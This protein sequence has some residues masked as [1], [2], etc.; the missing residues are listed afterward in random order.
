MTRARG[1]L[2]AAGASLAMMPSHLLFTSVLLSE[3]YFGFLLSAVLA[4]G[5]TVHDKAALEAATTSIARE[6]AERIWGLAPSRIDLQKK[7]AV[8]RL[9]KR[10]D[11]PIG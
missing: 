3:T 1:T 5:G 4:S 10:V 2:L 11:P 8:T 6:Y 7:V 9:M